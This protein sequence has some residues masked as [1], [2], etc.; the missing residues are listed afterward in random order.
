MKKLLAVGFI[1]ILLFSTLLPASQGTEN[2]SP[3]PISPDQYRPA[4][5]YNVQ[6]WIYIHVQGDPY[7]RG[8]QHGYLL[9]AE[10]V[11]MLNRWSNIIHNYPILNFFS[12]HLSDERYQKVSAAWWGF[13]VSR[14]YSWYQDKIPEEYQQEMQGIADGVSA[15]GG[16]IHG[17]NVTY[18]DI[19]TLNEMYEFMSKLTRLPKK[20][21]PLRSW[22]H[23]YKKIVP[24]S[25]GVSYDRF[26]EAF[27]NQDPAHHC[28]G[29][30]ATGNA[31][32]RV[33]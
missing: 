9:A 33:R 27:L 8:Y 28:N 23:Q 13:C 4:Y 14:C 15:R 6:G 18:K 5:R 22:F 2:S 12:K 30:I 32:F 10:I 17:R 7:D 20:V 25:N 11:D 21:N 16:T 3:V 1:T 31:T 29:F 24:E 19:L 26:I